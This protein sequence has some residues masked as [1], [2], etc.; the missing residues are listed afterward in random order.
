MY[1][2]S[3]DAALAHVRRAI[4]ELI[5]VEEIG[6]LISDLDAL[7]LHKMVAGHM[8]EAVMN[9]YSIAPV[10]MLNGKTAIEGEE[11]TMTLKNGVATIEMKVP[12]ARVLSLKCSD[13]EYVMFDLI[14]ED[15]AEGRKQLNLY[16]RGTYDDPRLVLQK[17]WAGDFLPI[18]RY[19]STKEL[20]PKNVS[21]DIEY[22]PYPILEGGVIEIPQRV[23]YAILNNLVAHVLD[24]YKEF[25]AADR[26][27]AK[28]KN[29]LEG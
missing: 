21:F 13:S 23:E 20:N 16:T 7:N 27:R 11:Y 1:Q 3:V 19:Y 29:S 17:V 6:L 26:F 18:L 24:S 5:S 28:A 4:D 22:L 2:L 25:E 12:T 15:S 14:P 9:I 10:L 8:E